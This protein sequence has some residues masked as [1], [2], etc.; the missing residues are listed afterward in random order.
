MPLI[1][2]SE[3]VTGTGSTTVVCVFLELKEI[4]SFS[5]RLVKLKM[6]FFF[7]DLRNSI[8]RPFWWK[9]GFQVRFNPCPKE[10]LPGWISEEE[11]NELSICSNEDIFQ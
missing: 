1:S 7:P 10:G 2:I 3:Q 11:M 5:L 6:P 8:H 9:G 4:S